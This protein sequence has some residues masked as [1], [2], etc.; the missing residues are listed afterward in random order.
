MRNKL[1]ITGTLLMFCCSLLFG[2]TY[3]KKIVEKTKKRLES[4][5]KSDSLQVKAWDINTFSEYTSRIVGER[6]R[7]YTPIGVPGDI[8]FRTA[9]LPI[10]FYRLETDSAGNWK[11]GT[12]ISLGGSYIWGWGNGTLNSDSS[13][14]T[15]PQFFLGF[16][17][18]FG[19]VQD[20]NNVAKLAPSLTLGGILGFSTFAVMLGEDV[21]N[22]TPIIGVAYNISGF[23]LLKNLTHFSDYP[24][25]KIGK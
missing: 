23:P 12:T 1:F 15:E 9:S 3:S 14:T 7:E 25:R 8:R 10:S 2:Q 24:T 20:K 21:L 4:K 6:Q 13:I 19:V 16:T 5:F 17:G 18:N 11:I 22:K